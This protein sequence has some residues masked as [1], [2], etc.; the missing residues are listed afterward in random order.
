MTIENAKFVLD[1]TATGTE[2]TAQENVRTFL[3]N[4]KCPVLN[5]AITF[6]DK[7]SSAT[8]HISEDQTT[9][10]MSSSRVVERRT[11][12]TDPYV[13]HPHNVV[14]ILRVLSHMLQISKLNLS[15]IHEH[16]EQIR[17]FLQFVQDNYERTGLLEQ[18][19]QMVKGLPFH[20]ALNGQFVSLMDQC[21]SYALIPSGV[22][23]NQLDELQKQ[24]KCRFLNPDALPALDKLY[25]DLGVKAGEN[26]AQFY[27]EYVFK[28]FSMFARESQIQHLIYI[29]DE[30][31]PFRPDTEML[32]K[33]MIENPCIPDKDGD[34]HFAREFFD[35]TN[36]VFNVMFEDD[37]DMFPPS[38][39]SD[40][41]WLQLL[42]DVGLQVDITPQLFLQF[43]TTV[44]E[45]G[46]RSSGNQRNRERSEVLVKC[47][48]SEK[49]LHQETFLSQVSQIKFIAPAK[50]EEELI[51]IHRQHVY[52][53]NAIPPLLKFRDAVP[54]YYRYLTWT[55][56]SILPIWAQPNNMSELKNLRIACS[57][58]P[59]AMFLTI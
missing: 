52:P 58:P 1:M 14:D 51:S 7:H 48:F 50:V 28:H 46:K 16:E 30:V 2:S 25:R 54:W 43:C 35:P 36:K 55:T 22:P 56:A 45:D 12:V 10:Q 34:L 44:A 5:K 42:E 3:S 38:P 24:A 59:Y 49:A 39:F 19:K 6:E 27:V 4:L 8:N 32:R 41:D 53:G 57:G 18:C 29:R 20:K 47:L 15:G 23:T 11:A 37:Y 17:N 26:V 9:T 13:A 40:S 31:Y 33:T 21:C